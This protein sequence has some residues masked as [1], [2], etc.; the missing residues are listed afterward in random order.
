MAKY[1]ATSASGT[2][3][4][5]KTSFRRDGA[6]REAFEFDAGPGIGVLIGA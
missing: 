5:Q 2:S 6:R 4:N 1:A 3:N